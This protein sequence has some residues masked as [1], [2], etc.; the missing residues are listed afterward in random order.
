[1]KKRYLASVYAD[2]TTDEIREYYDRW[3]EVYDAELT[4]NNYQQP[5][6]CARTM[7]GH[8]PD[9]NAR[10]LDVGC[11]TGLSGLALFEAGYRHIDGCDLSN[12]MLE[13]A[14]ETGVYSKLFIADLNNP[15]L[16]AP[17]AFYD[18]VAAVGIFSKAHVRPDALDE[19]LRISKY[20]A[21]IVIGLNDIFYREGDFRKK[22]D[23]LLETES[24]ALISKEFGDHIPGTG[25]SGWVITMANKSQ[26][27]DT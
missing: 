25:L 18:A 17:N 7:L 12:G 3:S 19:F 23:A 21:P 10:I 9:L 22:L 11:G 15:P 4:E 16:D 1:M 5:R 27:S 24:I 14:F 20:D 8:V 13:K 6:R 2:R 26:T